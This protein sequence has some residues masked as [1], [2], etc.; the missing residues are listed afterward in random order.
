MPIPRIIHFTIP[1]KPTSTQL[2]CIETARKLH[3]GWQIQ[4]WQDPLN[5]AEFSLGKYWSKTNSGAQLADLIRLDAVYRHGG[6][7]LDSDLT[8][9][10]S[11]EG[12]CDFPFVI[13][14][15][16]GFRLTNAF[17]GA[18]AGSPALKR[19][20]D[21]LDNGEVDWSLPPNLTTGP[22]LFTRELKWRKDVTVIP[23]ESFYPFN[24]NE[25][26]S[27][28]RLWTY[29][30]HLWAHSWGE[31]S[32]RTPLRK[33][34]GSLKKLLS[35]FPRWMLTASRKAVTNGRQLWKVET[36][37]SYTASGV[38]CAQ[39]IH[40]PKI[41][42]LGEDG[43]LTPEIALHGTYEFL[44]ERFIKRVVR[45]GDWAIDVGANIGML[46]ILCAQSVGPF[47]RVFCYEPNPLPGSLL[48]RSIAMN[49][50]HAQTEVRQ[51]AVGSAPGTLQLR[52]SK[53]RL[54]DATLV[55][56]D[57]ANTF[58]SSA[59][60]L[61]A[62]EEI[63]VEVSTLEAEFPVDLPIRLLKVDAEGYEHHVLRGGTRL[64]ERH[65]IDILMLE[66]IQDVY[67][68]QWGEFLAEIKKLIEYGYEPY[69]L[70]RSS[71]LKKISYNNILYSNRGR[72][73]I[74]VSKHAKDTI[75]EL[76]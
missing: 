9:H 52:F 37:K 44:E 25:K 64:L 66:C 68:Q 61:A 58:Q 3:P 60:L 33:L 35:G 69:T 50:L 12:L 40:G 76:A 57:N 21:S 73:V 46:S 55:S 20:M 27:A 31:S 34:A 49:W 10:R 7:Y 16:D 47:G 65:C 51:K 63:A 38:I 39:T 48:K 1:A 32:S 26:P 15:E 19:L 4:V 30:T 8:L 54:G 36:P 6:F 53:E 5:A 14:S 72:N 2:E 17:F 67:G 70:S 71:R 56:S 13:C 28:A 43:S 62:E 59:L 42:L 41:Y 75:K 22:H 24:Y 45:R 29:G 23:R 74:F 18:E 11:L